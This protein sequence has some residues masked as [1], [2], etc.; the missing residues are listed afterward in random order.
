MNKINQHVEVLILGGGVA[1]CATALGLVQQGVQGVMLIDKPLHLPFRVGESATPDVAH[2]L[3]ELGLPQDLAQLGHRPYHGNLS[4]W[5]DT[6]TVLDH[7]LL[8]GK[9][10]GWHL[11]RT[12]F[13]DYLRQQTISRG[14][15]L[16]SPSGI[17][18]I[19]AD[20]NGWCVTIEK[21]GVVHAR[22]LVDAAGRRAPLAKRLGVKRHRLDKLIALAVQITPE[23]S[24]PCKGLSLLEACPYGWWYAAYLPNG[25]IIITLMTDHDVAIQQHFYDAN[26]YLSAWRQTQL[27][28]DT[29]KPPLSLSKPI[30]SFAAH[31]GFVERAAGRN[32]LAVG[33]ALMA[34]DPLT[35]SGI[36]GAFNDAKAAVTVIE[37]QLSS[38]EP[39]EAVRNYTKRANMSLQRYLNER[40]QHY[41]NGCR[42]PEQIFWQRRI[43]IQVF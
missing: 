2:A 1:G 8:R 11:D 24:S 3:S 13:D 23:K 15:E 38:T 31:S 20:T 26:T 17:H 32:W 27:L 22:V 5:G 9:G 4:R 35:S 41:R 39:V 19:N 33:D 29:I 28:N 10:H 40:Q 43:G 7:F 16:I 21:K 25:Q 14:I 30:A 18:Q 34:F 6:K 42:W 37:A 12:A 36:S